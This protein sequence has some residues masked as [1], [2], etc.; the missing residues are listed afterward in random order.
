[1]WRFFGRGRRI[2]LFCGKA[3]SALTAHRAVFTSVRSMVVQVLWRRTCTTF[4]AN[5]LKAL[6]CG[7]PHR[8]DAS[9]VCQPVRTLYS[10][11]K[12]E[13]SMKD[14]SVFEQGQKD[15][16]PQQRFWRPTCYH[17]TM[18]LYSQQRYYRGKGI[19]CQAFSFRIR[20]YIIIPAAMA[21]FRDSAPPRIGRR[22]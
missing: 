16:N 13:P 21:A 3:G 4:R 20:S 7:T 22:R 17:Y 12:T 6:A 18:P 10:K 2:R 9:L 5:K 14:D 1:M 8:G 15:S 19:D 11:S